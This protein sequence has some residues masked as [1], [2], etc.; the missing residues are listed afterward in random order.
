MRLACAVNGGGYHNFDVELYDVT[1]VEMDYSKNTLTGLKGDTAYTNEQTENG[2]KIYY[3][4]EA[5][6]NTISFNTKYSVVSQKEYRL[7]A[8]LRIDELSGGDIT[9]N[10][11]FIDN[12]DGGDLVTADGNKWNEFTP[13]NGIDGSKYYIQQ[14]V[15]TA[16]SDKNFVLRLACNY[17][18]TYLVD[19]EIYDVTI[20]EFGVFVEGNTD[21][22][23]TVKRTQTGASVE[24]NFTGWTTPWITTKTKVESG[25]KYT[26]SFTVSD[27]NNTGLGENLAGCFVKYTNASNPYKALTLGEN[28]VT[29]LAD[30]DWIDS[31][32]RFILRFAFND[33]VGSNNTVTFTISDLTITEVTEA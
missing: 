12:E 29:V 30:S 22:F 19:A 4:R 20:E 28:T 27:F 7:T 6:W 18:G 11:F 8:K 3:N 1:L 25:K 16:K 32:G 24:L 5:Q 2:W 17:G 23:A 21:K 26:I 10:R 15:F 33:S 14:I 9:V 31:E 13:E